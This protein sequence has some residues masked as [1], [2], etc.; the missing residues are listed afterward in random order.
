M[1]IVKIKDI[2]DQ[3]DYLRENGTRNQNVFQSEMEQAH[4]NQLDMKKKTKK[5][6]ALQVLSEMDKLTREHKSPSIPTKYVIGTKHTD[7]T[8]N[9]L[10]KAIIQFINLSGGAAERINNLGR[11]VDRT[12][13]VTNSIG[14]HMRIGSVEWQKGTG[15][16]GTADISATVASLSVKIEVKIGRDKQSNDQ[17]KYEEHITEAGGVYI[18]ATEFAAFVR[19]YVSKFGRSEVF[20]K[21]LERLVA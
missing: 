5:I 1:S 9:G 7:R 16:K 4:Y 21:A 15:T 2:R 3:V 19:W 20:N 8:A 18:I 6:S 17:K 10:T 12:K 14:Q 11:M 13:V